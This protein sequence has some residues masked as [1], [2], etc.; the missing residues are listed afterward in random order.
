MSHEVKR[1]TFLMWTHV[2]GQQFRIL[3]LLFSDYPDTPTTA[4]LQLAN[5]SLPCPDAPKSCKFLKSKI[6]TI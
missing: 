5:K 6:P 2:S 3:E 1:E 4:T